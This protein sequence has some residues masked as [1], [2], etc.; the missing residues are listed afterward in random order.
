MY[1]QKPQAASCEV[2]AACVTACSTLAQILSAPQ[3]ATRLHTWSRHLDSQSLAFGSPGIERKV[4]DV[5][6]EDGLWALGPV[7][8]LLGRLWVAANRQERAHTKVP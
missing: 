5:R 7:A 3:V 4:Q 2:P 6:R 8:S 1:V